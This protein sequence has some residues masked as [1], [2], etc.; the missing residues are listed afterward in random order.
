MPVV[1][2]A[3]EIRDEAPA[4][5]RGARAFVEACRKGAKFAAATT[6][7]SGYRLAT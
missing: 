2:V 4:S 3:L 5:K 7:A 6:R 1:L